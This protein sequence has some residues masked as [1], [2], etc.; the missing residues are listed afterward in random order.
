MSGSEA[1]FRIRKAERWL[2]EQRNLQ[3]SRPHGAKSELMMILKTYRWVHFS[4]T[5]I[6]VG[7]WV[8]WVYN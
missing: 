4:E 8:R 3:G 2:R 6:N 5:R 1:I 7:K